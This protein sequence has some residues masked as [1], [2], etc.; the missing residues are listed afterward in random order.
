M[1]M[2]LWIPLPGPFAITSGGGSRKK[3][4]PLPL[5]FWP[6]VIVATIVGM[7]T[8]IGPGATPWWTL[9]ALFGSMILTELIRLFVRRSPSVGPDGAYIPRRA[10]ESDRARQRRLQ[11]RADEWARAHRLMD[12]AADRVTSRR[13]P[14]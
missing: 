1:R 14:Q 9:V 6:S 13:P 10:R 2:R 12:E 3:S 8:A 4:T 5:R 7:C 11:R